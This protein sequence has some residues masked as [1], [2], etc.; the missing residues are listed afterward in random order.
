VKSVALFFRSDSYILADIALRTG[1]PK[2][3]AGFSDEREDAAID[4]IEV[5]PEKN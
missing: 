4:D 1:G 2:M 3:I 5:L